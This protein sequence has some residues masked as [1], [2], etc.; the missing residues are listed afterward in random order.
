LRSSSASFLQT[1]SPIFLPRLIFGTFYQ[2]KVQQTFLRKKAQEPYLMCKL[3]F[4]SKCLESKKVEGLIS[5][6]A[7]LLFVAKCD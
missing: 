4:D 1:F 5:S 6:F 2:E 3:V 7:F